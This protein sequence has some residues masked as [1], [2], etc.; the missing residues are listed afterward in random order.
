MTI[1]SLKQKMIFRT[2]TTSAVVFV[3]VLLITVFLSYQNHL[4]QLNHTRGL[5]ERH[6]I[7]KGRTLAIDNKNT[8]QV[9]VLD[10]SQLSL[11]G[12]IETN[13]NENDDIVIGGFVTAEEQLWAW[14]DLTRQ[15]TQETEGE[16]PKPKDPAILDWALGATDVATKIETVKGHTLYWFAAPIYRPVGE[17]DTLVFYPGGEEPDEPIQASEP[18]ESD[19][20]AGA[21][22]YAL[23][24]Q[25]LLRDLAKANK[26]FKANLF[27]T[28]GLLVSLIF[29]AL[30]STFLATRRQAHTITQPLGILT[31][32]VDAVAAG[33]YNIEVEIHSGDEIEGLA[34][35]FN[36]MAKDLETSY[37]ALSKRARELE[38]ARGELEDLNKHLE[39]KVEERTKKLIES[40][41]KFRTLFDESADAILLSTEDRILDCNPA[42]LHLM[43]AD[44]KE[45]LLK[46]DAWQFYPEKQPDGRD[47][48]EKIQE[49]FNSVRDRG[50]R[51]FE[52][53]NRRLDGNDFFSEI[54]VT[55]FSLN[56]QRIRHQVIRDIT[57]RKR[58]EEA[59][60][61]AQQRLVE[62][63]H[64]AGMAEIAT[65]V[66]HNIGN[67]LNSVNISTE[68]IMLTLKNSKIK[69]FLKANEMVT[70]HKEDLSGFFTEHPKGKLIP[71]YY[72]SLGEAFS[73]EHGIMTEEIHALTNKVNMMR[74]VISTQQNYAKASL[75]T[76]D[77]AVVDLIEDSIKLQSAS[78]KKQ[79]VQIRRHYL[80]EPKGCLAKVK[81]VHVLTNLIKNAKEAMSNNDRENKPQLLDITIE[82]VKRGTC[83][84]LIED[85]GIG[86]SKENLEKIFNHGF[87]TK[88]DGHGFGLHTCANFMTEMGGTLIVESEGEGKGATFILTFPIDG[89]ESHAL[90]DS[91]AEPPQETDEDEETTEET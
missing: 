85:N 22:I 16:P 31:S 60:R 51:L 42:F 80:E 18:A 13:V 48:V 64:S 63:A 56:K 6:L 1:N 10:N 4:R 82:G 32:A 61:V 33:N 17:E 45:E 34:S 28:L 9:Y 87:T 43:A 70:E 25:N 5:Y 39:V 81:L 12:A 19:E 23:S 73:E 74:D 27:T 46:M 67:I 29:C 7:D 40:E 53:V 14:I 52:C 11:A 88:P 21:V 24:D 75:Y 83:R 49:I 30:L 41:T 57:E 50:S 55:T 86:I 20:L 58:T 26:E 78:L 89:K 44:N 72:I 69:G 59:L 35:S 71:G 15:N 3:I 54:V 91:H 79:G 68:E 8:L 77:I 66:L 2:M 37:E 38:I 36:K 62:T 90:M 47:S 76:E 65:G 84:I